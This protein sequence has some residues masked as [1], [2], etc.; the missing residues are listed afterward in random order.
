M[1]KGNPESLLKQCYVFLAN[2]TNITEGTHPDVSKEHELLWKFNF[3]AKK[4]LEEFPEEYTI[5]ISEDHFNE[6]G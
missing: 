3:Y 4:I 5:D 2:L 6:Q 1:S